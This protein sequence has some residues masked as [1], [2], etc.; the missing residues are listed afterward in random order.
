MM[1]IVTM[2]FMHEQAFVWVSWIYPLQTIHS[3]LFIFSVN[4]N[5]VVV[6]H[7]FL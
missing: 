6:C 5:E 7:S 1:T 2:K 4:V 3:G